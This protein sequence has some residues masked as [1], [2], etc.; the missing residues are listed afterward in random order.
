M[1]L[2]R[3]NSAGPPLHPFGRRRVRLLWKSADTRL[4]LG[5]LLG[6]IIFLF[7][8]TTFA[9]V[10]WWMGS[11]RPATAIEPNSTGSVYDEGDGIAF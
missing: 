3:R 6:W 5:L 4:V 8:R 2:F 9:L 1:G 7:G 11:R 10:G